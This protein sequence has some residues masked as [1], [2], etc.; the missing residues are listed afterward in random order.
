MADLDTTFTRLLLK[1]IHAEVRA[2]FPEI[3]NLIQAVGVTKFGSGQW[4]A[5][6]CTPNRA[7]FDWHG[8]AYNA[9]EARCKAWSAF[10]EKYA[11]AEESMS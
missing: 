3:P 10:L 9:W 11:T 5:Q 7:V 1:Q 8:R 4:I 6:I 2:E